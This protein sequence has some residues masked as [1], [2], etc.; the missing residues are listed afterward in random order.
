MI[1]TSRGSSRRTSSFV[2]RSSFAVPVNSTGF[3]GPPPGT[4]R[5]RASAGAPPAARRPRAAR[6]ACAWGRPGPSR[7][8]SG[9]RRRDAICGRCVIVTTC[10]RSARRRNVSPTACAVLPP[11]PASISSKTIVSPP[12]TAAIASAIR[13]SS[14]PE[15]VSATGANG[16]PGF[17][18][19]R[20]RD[21]VGAG[22]A[23]LALAELGD[24][25]ALAEADALELARRPPPRTGR[26]PPRRACASSSVSSR[27]FA[28]AAARASRRGGE[29]V[30]AVV[31]RLELGARLGRAREQLLERRAAEA[32]LRLGDPVE[33]RLDLLEPVRLG[34][35]R[36]E[37]R[38]QLRR[39]SRSRTSTSRSSPAAVCSS[40]ASCSSG[41]ERTLGARRRDRLRPRR[42]PARAPRPP[43]RRPA[44]AR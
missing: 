9:G 1:A 11:M 4:P 14:P 38:A 12:P 8:G 26:R 3:S 35:E 23:R 5:R 41:C 32:P 33:L 31:E 29:R 2:R 36:G 20:K 44:R 19:I 43:R 13:E 6:S 15:A 24:E 17:G 7:P 40:G 34:L 37:E 27:V 30:D 25:L 22:R 18:R 21:L 42:P 16:R 10:A 28:S 39:V